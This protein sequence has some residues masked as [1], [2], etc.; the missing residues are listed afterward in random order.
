MRLKPIVA[1]ILLALMVA[2]A[3]PPSAPSL[4][5]S[6]AVGYI[7]VET[8]A[9]SALVAHEAGRISDEHRGLARLALQMAKNSLDLASTFAEAGDAPAAV[10]KTTEAFNYF[11]TVKRLLGETP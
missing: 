7:T 11:D 8:L 4:E 1:A 3:T 10:E 2:C 9:E 6:I 5:E